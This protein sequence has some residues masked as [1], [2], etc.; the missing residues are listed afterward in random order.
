M[1]TY[2]LESR[3]DDFLP[4]QLSALSQHLTGL[5]PT[6]RLSVP[7]LPCSSTPTSCPP[8]GTNLATL[9]RA[10]RAC[11]LVA[12]HRALARPL[13]ATSRVYAWPRFVWH[14]MPTPC[15]ST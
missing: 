12:A 10:I 15:F 7:V 5:I 6:L 9:D 11:L 14:F 1:T 4:Q 2:L 8:F 3:I 13:T